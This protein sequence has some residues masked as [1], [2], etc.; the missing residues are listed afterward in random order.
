MATREAVS[1]LNESHKNIQQEHTVDKHTS[2]YCIAEAGD[3][4]TSI[5]CKDLSF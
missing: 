4:H 2:K 3:K 1:G 5:I